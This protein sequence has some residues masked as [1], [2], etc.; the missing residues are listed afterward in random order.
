MV[1]CPMIITVDFL[2]MFDMFYISID[3]VV[4]W[5]VYATRDVYDNGGHFFSIIIIM[6]VL[7]IDSSHFFVQFWGFIAM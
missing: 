5:L 7:R 3:G 1:L 6:S 4:V 2:V